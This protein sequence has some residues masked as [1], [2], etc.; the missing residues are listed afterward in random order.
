MIID[1]G[2]ALES[3]EPNGN[4]EIFADGTIISHRGKTIPSDAEIQAEVDRLQAAYD[5]DYCQHR[6]AEYPHWTIQL[7]KI[8]DDG[9]TKWKSE[10]IDPI[11]TKWPKDNSGP[12]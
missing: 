11:K 9:V 1:K 3:L 10:M 5:S 8:Y 4:Y 6:E 7:N 2:M 12:V